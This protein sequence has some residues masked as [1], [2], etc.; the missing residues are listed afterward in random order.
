MGA[1]HAVRD[2]RLVVARFWATSLKLG[3]AMEK[4]I[5]NIEKIVGFAWLILGLVMLAVQNT[6]WL[7]KLY[8]GGDA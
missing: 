8:I 4:T 5:H 3:D 7:I 2:Y 6:S 1:V